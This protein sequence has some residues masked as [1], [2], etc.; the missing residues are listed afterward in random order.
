MKNITLWIFATN[1]CNC[2]CSYCKEMLDNSE[3]M[4][5]Q[6]WNS[7]FSMCLTLKELNKYDYFHLCISGGEPLLA[8]ENYKD[9][10]AYYRHLSTKNHL[11]SA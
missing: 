7:L 8:F 3:V 5:K 10:V 9:V 1:E 11:I 4:S 2:C 6:N